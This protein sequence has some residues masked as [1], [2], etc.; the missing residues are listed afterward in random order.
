LAVLKD[1]RRNLYQDAARLFQFVAPVRG[2]FRSRDCQWGGLPDLASWPE[3][4]VPVRVIRCL[5]TDSVR[6][7]LDQKD[8]LQTSDWGWATTLPSGRVS[9]ERCVG[10]GH[11]RW[12]IENQGS[13][14][15]PARSCA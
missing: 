15:R 5:E 8:E 11:Q 4:N 1:E 6:R 2:T 14:N 7:Q 12:D 9:A 10:F 13:C 3:V